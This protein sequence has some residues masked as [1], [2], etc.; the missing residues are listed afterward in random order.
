MC[1]SDLIAAQHIPD[2]IA[3]SMADMAEVVDGD[4][5]AVDRDLSI[6]QGNELLTGAGEGV[7]EPQGHA[8][9]RRRKGSEGHR[10][11]WPGHAR[12]LLPAEGSPSLPLGRWQR[13]ST[14]GRAALESEAPAGWE[15]LLRLSLTRPPS[16]RFA[17]YEVDWLTPFAVAGLMGSHSSSRR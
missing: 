1:S 4:A 16:R 12:P 6:H 11:A 7:G 5:A 9:E 8:A 15:F 2:Q 17:D 3:A 10:K 14:P 13:H